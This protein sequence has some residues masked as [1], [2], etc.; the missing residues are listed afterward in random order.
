MC[1]R[2]VREGFSGGAD[3]TERTLRLYGRLTLDGLFEQC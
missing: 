1:G 3:H 2:D